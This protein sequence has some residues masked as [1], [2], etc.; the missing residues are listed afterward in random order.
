MLEAICRDLLDWNATGGEPVRLLLN[1]SSQYL[2]QGDFFGKL[3]MRFYATALHLLRLRMRS[4]F[5]R[6]CV[7]P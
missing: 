4:P 2:D 6:C 5:F 3:K 1:L 7:T